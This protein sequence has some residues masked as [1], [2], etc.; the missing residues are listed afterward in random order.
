M[1]KSCYEIEQDENG[2][3]IFHSV[4][5]GLK[6]KIEADSWLKDDFNEFIIDRKLARQDVNDIKSELD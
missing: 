5:G 2:P 3:S 6:G 4:N 1:R